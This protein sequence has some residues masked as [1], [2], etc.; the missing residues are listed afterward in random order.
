MNNNVKIANELIGIV[1]TL[2]SSKSNDPSDFNNFKKHIV[3]FCKEEKSSV[4]EVNKEDI[5]NE[6]RK[7]VE[8]MDKDSKF[9]M[10]R[11]DKT[12]TRVLDILADDEN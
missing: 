9:D 8:S 11:S 6:L 5:K 1:K 4:K 2:T 3:D 10:S 12:D 7:K